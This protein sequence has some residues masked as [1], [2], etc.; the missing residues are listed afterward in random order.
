MPHQISPPLQGGEATLAVRTAEQTNGI[1]S[2]EEVA[3]LLN[4]TFTADTSQGALD[5]AYALTHLLTGS[6]G[7]RGLREYGILAEIKKAAADKKSGAKRESA[8]ILLGALVER[9]PPAQPLSEVVFLLQ[10]TGCITWALDAL[11]DKGAVVRESAEYALDALYKNLKPESKVVGLLPVLTQ[12]LGKRSGKWQGTVGAYGYM[13]KMAN[14]AK[15][16][17]G[18]KEEEKIKD[19]LRE[20]MGRKLASL[21][22][23]VE[24]GMHDLKSEA[25]TSALK[26][27]NCPANTYDRLRSRLG[28]LWRLLPRFSPTT[29]S[30]LEYR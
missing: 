12:Y 24:A 7:F 18:G 26:G 22:P 10:E 30:P 19:V 23:V 6:V 9:F 15:M 2:R 14:D 3:S 8:M 25:S 16:G 5:A 17:M 4:T 29:T 11:A 20:S 21:I 13:E 1:P 28:R 27:E